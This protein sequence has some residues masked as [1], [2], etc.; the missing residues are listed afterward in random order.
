MTSRLNP[1]ISFDGD[2]RRA[3]EFY[4]EGFG[5]ARW[6]DG[7]GMGADRVGVPWMVNLAQPQGGSGPYAGSAQPLEQLGR[8][9]GGG[10]R[11]LAGDEIAVDD[12]VRRPRLA[13]LDLD[14]GLGQ[15][16]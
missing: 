9:R 13:H 8:E 3:M 7:F 14:A 16:V 10:G 6:G 12:D 1:Y 15:P 5:G 2:A 11:V 4:Q